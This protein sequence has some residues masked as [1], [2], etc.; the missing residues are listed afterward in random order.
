VAESRVSG[1]EIAEHSGPD[2]AI[3]RVP[4]GVAAFC[5]RT[6]KGPLNRPIPVSNFAEY[7]QHF[8]GLWQPSTLSY[9]VEQFFENG[10]REA[11]IVRV[12]N[13]ARA[14]TLTLPAGKERLQL[15][16][17][18]PGS[19]EYLRASVD[20]DGIGENE[21]D[22]FNLVLQRVRAANSELIEEQEIFRRL[23]VLEETG[24]GVATILMDSRLARVVGEVP[25]QRPDRSV[26]NPDSPI[27]GYINSNADGDDGAPLTDYDIIG[28]ATD[29]TG[30]FALR[31]VTGFNLLCIP[32][33]SRDTDVGMS[34]LVIAARFCRDRHAML[35]VDPPSKWTSATTAL[36]ELRDWPFRS[37]NAVMFYPRVVALDRLRGRHETFG[38]CGA[39]AGMIA[40][41]DETWP[42]WAAAESEEAILR[43]GLRPASVVTDHERTRLAQAGVNTLVAV[44]SSGKSSANQR[45]LAAGSSA[46]PDWKYLSARR[47]ALFLTASIERGTRWLI[48]EQNA[49]AAWKRAREQVET[50]LE[51]LDTQGAFAGSMPEESYFVICDERVNQPRTIAE[52][53][54]KLLFGIAT[55]KPGDFHAWLITH[56]PGGVSTCRPSH[57][58]RLA[59]SGRRVEWEIETSI[60]RGVILE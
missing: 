44:R 38:S 11:Y 58:N 15:V 13:G 7:T 40:R 26:R 10:G 1:I 47:L 8:G 37:E 32:P 54:V 14:P 34:T 51:S 16:A 52:G 5:G 18:N 35:V 50:F 33:L 48:F 22:R 23:S 49:P 4:T 19:R 31:F 57:P 39:A 28:S 59:T 17:L 42:V 30:I 53:K 9:A 24:R 21:P 25:A 55:T 2:H 56:Q 12:A 36:T 20:Y 27:V 60:L 43:P 45:T 3:D 29:G 46:S 6:L 41:A